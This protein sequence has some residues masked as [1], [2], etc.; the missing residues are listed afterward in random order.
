MGVLHRRFLPA[1]L[2][3]AIAALI[4][5]GTAT[6]ASPAKVAPG[7]G[8]SAQAHIY[9]I[10]NDHSGKCLETNDNAG[11]NGALVQQWGCSG[12]PSTQWRLQFVRFEGTVE[13]VTIRHVAHPGKCLEIPD[14]STANGAQAQLWDCLNQSSAE[15]RWTTTPG[16]GQQFV[17][18]HSG[19]CLEIPD[20]STADGAVAQQWQCLGQGS[21]VWRLW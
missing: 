1:L 3:A 10:Y 5:P 20:W 9:W 17:N 11:H 6:A 21:A 14:W 4:V 7:D 2:L 19:K 18:Q 8:V 13:V 12:Q 16:G 15:W